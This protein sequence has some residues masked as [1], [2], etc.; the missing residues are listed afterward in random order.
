MCSSRTLS[1]AWCGDFNDALTFAV[2]PRIVQARDGIDQGSVTRAVWRRGLLFFESQP[3]SD[4]VAQT[5]FAVGGQSL[6]D[7]AKLLEIG[8]IDDLLYP[9]Y[10]EDVELSWRAWKRGYE[11][12]YAPDAV[13]HHIG[14][15]SSSRA[16]SEA[17]LRAV[18][19]QNQLLIVWKNITDRRLMVE[20]A[21]CLPLRLV[22]AAV[23]RDWPT[24]R[25]FARATRR[26]RRVRAARANARALSRRSDREVL[27]RV[28]TLGSGHVQPD[29][30][31]APAG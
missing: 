16:F 7:H 27:N 3:H 14:G 11:V 2:C 1:I 18:V 25:G 9:M 21:I 23:K 19:R 26:L 20:H 31:T 5:F 24:I 8:T 4:Q 10:G 22:V 6:F 17:E 15:H 29:R 13:V 30:S 12:C 28:S